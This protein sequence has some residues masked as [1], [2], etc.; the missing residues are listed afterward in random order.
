MCISPNLI[1]NPNK[2][3]KKEGLNLLKDCTSTYI[4]VPC[5]HCP[6]CIATKQ[7]SIIQRLQQEERTHYLYYLTL[8]YRQSMIPELITS[9]GIRLH[10]IDWSD[11]Q[12]MFKRIRRYYLFERPLK[13]FAVSEFGEE[14]HRPHIHAIISVPK[15]KD[16]TPFLYLRYEK[17]LFDLFLAQWKRKIGGTRFKPKYKQC[18]RYIVYYKNGQRRSTYDFHYIEPYL[19]K[20]GSAD[21]SAYVTKYL[22]KAD[23]YVNRLQQALHLNL[24]IEE[25]NEVWRL[26]KPRYVQSHD[27]GSSKDE[28]VRTYLRECIEHSIRVSNMPSYYDTVSGKQMPLSRFYRNKFLTA[29]DA[30]TMYFN[31]K[32]AKTVDTIVDTFTNLYEQNIDLIESKFESNK[33]YINQKFNKDV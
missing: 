15:Y 4:A 11:W 8:T 6:Q 20:S 13:Y 28:E 32:H 2:G 33:Q 22:L 23:D 14:R 7:S 26:V 1:P 18:L 19:S 21:V 25:Y 30:F 27:T 3:R 17:Q 31:D 29:H 24:P 10:Y 16:D 9:Q 12:N 5:G